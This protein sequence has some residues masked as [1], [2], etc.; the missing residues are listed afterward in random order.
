MF[1]LFSVCSHF[2]PTLFLLFIAQE[3]QYLQGL[4]CVCSHFSHF[5]TGESTYIYTKKY[6]PLV[7]Q[8]GY[9]SV[10]CA[11]K[12]SGNIGNIGNRFPK[13]FKYKGFESRKTSKKVGTQWEQVGTEIKKR[14]QNGKR[15]Q[16]VQV[17][18]DPL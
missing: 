7:K 10:S 5:S 6:R 11:R 4:E 15:E 13:V 1:P 18:S 17:D 12:I 14:G 9:F 2:V 16:M 8:S 3:I